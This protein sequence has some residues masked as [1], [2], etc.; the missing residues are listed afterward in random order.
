MTTGR[1]SKY[2]AE[3]LPRMLQLY[4]EGCSDVEVHTELE[5][6]GDTFYRWI[7]ENPEF[8]ETVKQGKELSKAW[9]LAQAR[10]CLEYSSGPGTSRLDA[11]LW[12]MNMKNRF[13]WSDRQDITTGGNPLPEGPMRVVIVDPSSDS[14]PPSG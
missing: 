1:P 5:I 6:S 9:W 10:R 14:D 2:R 13:G 4:A 11:A 12:Y 3:M 7:K 8:S